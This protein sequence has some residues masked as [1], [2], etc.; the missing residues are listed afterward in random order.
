MKIF[1]NSVSWF[2]P[3]DESNEKKCIG[4]D[5]NRNWNY[6]WNEKG[7]SKSK[8][9]E[10]YAGPKPFSEPETKAVAKFLEENKNKFKVR[11]FYY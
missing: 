4:T 11:L 9:S 6:A 2:K 1:S 8:C 7:S 3:K 10:F 5:A